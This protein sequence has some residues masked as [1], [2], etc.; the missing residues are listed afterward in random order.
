MDHVF[1]WR[2]YDDPDLSRKVNTILRLG[3]DT[4]VTEFSNP[5]IEEHN[6]LKA[7][8]KNYKD[9]VDKLLHID[10][11]ISAVKKEL[12]P[13]V[14]ATDALQKDRKWAKDLR[15]IVDEALKEHNVQELEQEWK[16][17]YALFSHMR[18]M[19]T[20]LTEVNPEHKYTCS[21]CTA[22]L[23]DTLI[24]PCGH[25]LCSECCGRVRDGLHCPFCRSEII[26][27]RK[28]FQS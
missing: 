7:W 16:A 10:E 27:V 13:L 24:D 4:D 23:V 9:V 12:E 26:G 28:I 18:S 20:S 15:V 5:V 21:I 22:K 2:R 6:Q 25:T 14:Q 3:Q 11:C 19:W 1:T 17:Q 8:I